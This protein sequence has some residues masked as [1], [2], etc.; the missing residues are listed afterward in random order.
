MRTAPALVL[1]MLAVATTSNV[2]LDGYNDTDSPQDKETVLLGS[3]TWFVFVG[4]FCGI[5]SNGLASDMEKEAACDCDS[6][7]KNKGGD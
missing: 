5:S 4:S 1:Y 3:H 7:R 2:R 6:E